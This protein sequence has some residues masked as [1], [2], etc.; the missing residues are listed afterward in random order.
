MASD[1][2]HGEIDV[3]IDGL[4]DDVAFIWVLIHLGLRENPPREPRPP[5]RS[6][7]DAA[8]SSLDRLRRT[9][10]V[11]VGRMEYVDGGPPGRVAPLKHV[12]EP[13]GTVKRRVLTACGSGSDWEWSCW[14]MNT[15]SGDAA[16]RSALDS[17]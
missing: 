11:K 2:S 5:S 1:L 6:E 7:V 4:S 17:R 9:G 16:A 3:L 10:L 14:T 8:F 12:E 13:I 15:P